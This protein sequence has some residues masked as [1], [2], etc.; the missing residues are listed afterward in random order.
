VNNE[1]WEKII[2]QKRKNKEV[3]KVDGKYLFR[4]RE[5]EDL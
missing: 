3:K 1:D 4:E 2:E 5:K